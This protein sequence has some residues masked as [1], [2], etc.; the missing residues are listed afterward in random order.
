MGQIVNA[1]N[2]N[3]IR[4]EL[5][6]WVKAQ[7]TDAD[8]CEWEEWTTYLHNATYLH[9]PYEREREAKEKELHDKL[10][11]KYGRSGPSLY[12]EGLVTL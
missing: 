4:E 11:K 9:D 12:C 10:V 3:Q 2:V 6:E 7:L 1:E 5:M 8:F